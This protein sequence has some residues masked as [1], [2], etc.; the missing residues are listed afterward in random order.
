MPD[1]NATIQ[2]LVDDLVGRDPFRFGAEVDQHAVAHDGMRHDLDVFEADV[3]PAVGQRARLPPSTRA[4]RRGRWRR[5][6]R[7][8]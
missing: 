7:I 3:C 4:A 1:G 2:Q 8:S 6:K 5:T